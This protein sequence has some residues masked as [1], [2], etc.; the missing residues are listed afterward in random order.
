MS[1]ARV[2]VSSVVVAVVLLA[3]SSVAYASPEV[4]AR[5]Y[6]L[7]TAGN[8][9]GALEA[10]ESLPEGERGTYLFA[11]RR[12]WLLYQVGRYDASVTGYRQA[13]TLAPESLEAPLGELLPLLAQRRWAEAETRARAVLVRDADNYLAGR[14][15]AFALFGLGRFEESEQVYRAVSRR[16]PSDLEVV[17]GI[18]WCQARRGHRDEAAATFRSVL[19]VSPEDTTAR[20][21]L[22]AATGAEPVR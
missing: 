20:A 3:G 5:S 13:A 9:A 18:A 22:T 2:V 8:S 17:T 10:L 6:S 21:G 19:A 15:L 1:N 16:Y 4:W 12:A 7:E 14:R 11:L